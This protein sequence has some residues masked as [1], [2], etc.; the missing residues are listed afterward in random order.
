MKKLDKAWRPE[1]GSDIDWLPSKKEGDLSNRR[2][3]W[4]SSE[5]EALARLRKEGK[6]NSEIALELRRTVSG[7]Q[8]KISRMGIA[9]RNDDWT[10]EQLRVLWEMRS[11][12]TE[13]IQKRLLELGGDRTDL[14]VRTMLK[15]VRARK[16]D[17]WSD[18]KFEALAILM[19]LRKS[20]SREALRMVLCDGKTVREAEAATGLAMQGIY[21]LQASARRVLGLARVVA[22]SDVGE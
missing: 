21:K 16:A 14:A 8:L 12:G 5:L 10:D 17:E 1:G 6:S 13:A 2:Q 18:A 3:Q 20:P 7:V 15:K 19:R 9:D 4:T 11:K 22:G